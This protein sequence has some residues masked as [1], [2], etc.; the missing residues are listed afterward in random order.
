[1]S[2]WCDVMRD[3]FLMCQLNYQDSLSSTRLATN[4]RMNATKMIIKLFKIT[5]ICYT[6][7]VTEN[8]AA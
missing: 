6:L 5:L 1:M 7:S 4:L 3:D 8:D 2:R